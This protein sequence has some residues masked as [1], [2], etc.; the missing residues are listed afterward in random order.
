MDLPSARTVA[1]V[2]DLFALHEIKHHDWHIQNCCAVTGDGLSEGLD[3][4]TNK[5]CQKHKVSGLD[6]K[7]ITRL[8]DHDRKAKLTNLTIGGTMDDQSVELN[9]TGRSE[10]SIKA[11]S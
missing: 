1:E 5:L 8:P 6:S 11:K 2:T 7:N 10:R 3:W 4:L 9:M